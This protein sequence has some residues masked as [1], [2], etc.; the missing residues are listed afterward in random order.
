[1]KRCPHCLR[2]IPYDK[3][4][5][6]AVSLLLALSAGCLVVHWPKYLVLFVG[7]FWSVCVGVIK[8]LYDANNGGEFSWQDLLFDVIGAV[9]GVVIMSIVFYVEVA[10]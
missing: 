6:F 3:I 8:E 10:P 4:L 9:C 5:H 7:F 1:M 2:K